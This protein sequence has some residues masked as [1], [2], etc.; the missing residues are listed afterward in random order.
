MNLF[1][2]WRRRSPRELVSRDVRFAGEQDGEPERRLKAQFAELFGRRADIRR[3]YLARVTNDSEAGV[4]LC[5]AAASD[6]PD[7]AILR[8]VG[9]IFADIFNGKE[10]LDVVFVDDEREAELKRVCAS[11]YGRSTPTR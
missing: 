8:E 2:R 9:A 5:L 1:G 4:A 7:T 11:F 3:A 10:Y 6:D